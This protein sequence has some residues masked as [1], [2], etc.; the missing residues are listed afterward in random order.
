MANL[1][2][3]DFVQSREY[4][5]IQLVNDYGE[6]IQD[7]FQG[8][9]FREYDNEF[10][11][12]TYWQRK[13]RKGYKYSV[14]KEK[15]E[16]MEEE[17]IS[18]AEFGIDV[19]KKKLFIFGNKHM[20]QRIV[21]LIGMISQY[22]YSITEYIVDMEKLVNRICKSESIELLKMKLSDIVIEHGLL[23][24]CDVSLMN[25]D[26]PSGIAL[27]YIANIIVFSFI[28]ENI[29]T[30]VTVYKTGKIS[31]NKI[32]DNDKEEIVQKII[33]LAC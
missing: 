27:R 25:Q 22:S 28:L 14:E 21:T 20:A 10:L 19:L 30:V 18:V 7:D 3:Y 5:L 24:N 4:T 29:N 6:R 26:N 15:F 12:A 11:K 1:I 23:A 13:M 33:Q 8:V 9:L 31:I 32:T 17:I 2:L 16:E